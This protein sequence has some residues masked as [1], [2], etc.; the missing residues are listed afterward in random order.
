MREVPRST[1]RSVTRE[2]VAAAFLAL[3]TPALAQDAST[4]NGFSLPGVSLPSGTDEV[5]AADGTSCR[6]AV[7]GNGAYVDMGMIGK[8]AS[9]ADNSSYYGRV[10]IPL[11]RA[12]KRLDCTKLYDLEVERLKLELELAKAGMGRAEDPELADSTQTSS[13]SGEQ[14]VDQAFADPAQAEQ[15]VVEP[16]KG[17]KKKKQVTEASAKPAKAK[18]GNASWADEGWSDDGLKD[19]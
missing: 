14:P 1:S 6:S 11:G 8:S 4:S 16:Q 3:A 7:G 2:L 15:P 18:I 19:Q 12:P 9:P 5:R 13:V 10:V 17:K